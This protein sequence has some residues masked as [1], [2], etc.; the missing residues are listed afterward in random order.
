MISRDYHQFAILRALI[1]P[2]MLKMLINP[3]LQLP[4][5]C[6]GKKTAGFEAWFVAEFEVIV[7][8][9][10]KAFS[11]GINV[12]AKCDA[13]LRRNLPKQCKWLVACDCA[14]QDCLLRTAVKGK[15]AHTKHQI[16]NANA[17]LEECDFSHA[18][19]LFQVHFR[20]GTCWDSV[21]RHSARPASIKASRRYNN[22]KFSGMPTAPSIFAIPNPRETRQTPYQHC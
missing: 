13:E 1:E 9:P 10:A 17:R 4:K 18:T 5:A 16:L 20:H 15:L 11:G 2:I 12:S 21:L 6:N 14:R 3:C 7:R 19:W 8:N 22:D